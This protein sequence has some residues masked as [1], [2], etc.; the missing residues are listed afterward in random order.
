MSVSRFLM[1]SRSHAKEGASPDADVLVLALESAP[2]SGGDASLQAGRTRAVRRTR[3]NDFMG[4]VLSLSV[5]V[6][7][8]S[9]LPIGQYYSAGGWHSLGK[10]MH[11]HAKIGPSHP[12]STG[13]EPAV[14]VA[15]LA[16]NANGDTAGGADPGGSAELRHQRIEI[17]FGPG[18]DLEN[19][20]LVGGPTLDQRGGMTDREGSHV[21]AVP[22]HDRVTQLV[23]SG[24]HDLPGVVVARS[25]IDQELPALSQRQLTFVR[26]Q[27]GQRDRL[28]P[29]SGR[30]ERNGQGKVPGSESEGGIK[31]DVVHRSRHCLETDDRRPALLQPVDTGGDYGLADSLPLIIG[32]NGERTHPSLDPRLM[33]HVEG[34]DG[35]PRGSPDHRPVLRIGDGELPH[36]GVEVRDADSHHTVLAIALGKRFAEH[37]VELRN[38]AGGDAFRTLGYPGV[39]PVARERHQLAARASGPES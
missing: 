16:L 36:K 18:H 37:G 12:S 29:R 33:H 1:S 7:P 20:H 26:V 11:G 9:D 22:D 35:I 17:R 14:H 24:E 8:V 28:N 6:N 4:P 15:I 23:L 10:P 2:D 5:T 21:G 13:H 3:R 19:S 39:T 25:E 30:L 32:M 34:G 31:P 38:F 27:G